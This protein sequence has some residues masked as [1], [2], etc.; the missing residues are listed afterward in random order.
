MDFKQQLKIAYDKDA[1]RR[2]SLE[3]KRDQWKL[4]TRQHFIELLKSQKGK[5]I[6]ELGSGAG[7]DAKF[8]KDCGFDVLATDLSSEMIKMCLKRGL[9]AKML[10]L[11]DLETLGKKFDAIFSMNVLLHVPKSDI[12]DVLDNIYKTLN[13]GGLFFYGVYGGTDEEKTIVDD[14]KM[15]LPRL[16]SFLSDKSLLKLVKDKFEVLEFK[17][18]DNGSNIPNFHFQSLFLKKKVSG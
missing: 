11:Y 18:I 9:N 14:S 17:T 3:D 5:S 7:L 13:D 6:L 4:D 8:F 2:D 16:F 15:G 12:E 10:D 1:K